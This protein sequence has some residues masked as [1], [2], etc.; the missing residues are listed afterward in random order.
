[1]RR[2]ARIWRPWMGAWRAGCPCAALGMLMLQV[3]LLFWPLALGWARR[4]ERARQQQLCLDLI[5]QTYAPLRQAAT[6]SQPSS[7]GAHG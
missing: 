7:E 5:A 3:S 1:M 6:T 2:E 4:F